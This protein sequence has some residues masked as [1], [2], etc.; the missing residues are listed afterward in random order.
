MP[1]AIAS[2]MATV[3]DTRPATTSPRTVATLNVAASDASGF[4]S[5]PVTYAGDKGDG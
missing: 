1:K 2:G 5:I 3:E 4:A